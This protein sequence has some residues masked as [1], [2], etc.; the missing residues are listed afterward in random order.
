PPPPHDARPNPGTI[1]GTVTDAGT[2]APLAGATDSYSGGSTTTNASGQYSLASVAEG[3]YTVTASASGY[4]S[5]N[6][7][8]SVGPGA[9]VTQNFALVKPYGAISGTV[10]DAATGAPIN[11]A[12]VSYS[13]GSTATN[14]SGQYTL[15]NVPPGNY[16]VTAS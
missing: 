15:P 11:A 13:G 8:V 12:T 1:T 5:Q 16:V 7:T 10:I 3:S 9:T 14:A 6:R 2:A 4:T